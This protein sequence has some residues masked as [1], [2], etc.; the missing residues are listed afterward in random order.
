[1]TFPP[2]YLSLSYMFGI[3]IRLIPNIPTCSANLNVFLPII[4]WP[5]KVLLMYSE[6]RGTKWSTQ[7]TSEAEQ[8]MTVMYWCPSI[9]LQPLR[10]FSTV[11][12]VILIFVITSDILHYKIESC[13]FKTWLLKGT[14][15]LLGWNQEFKKTL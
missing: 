1:M 10:S 12:P 2:V 6:N 8:E 14:L 13:C 3:Y 9:I 7:I 4:L 5:T 11:N 15:S